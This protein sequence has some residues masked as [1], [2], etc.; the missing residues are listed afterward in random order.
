[1]ASSDREM[2]LEAFVHRVIIAA[3]IVVGLSSMGSAQ[4]AAPRP[5]HARLD[6]FAGRWSIEGESEGAKVLLTET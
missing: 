3:L 2:S 4:L 1:M 6:T 5:E